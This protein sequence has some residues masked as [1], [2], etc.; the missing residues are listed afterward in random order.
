LS[1]FFHGLWERHQRGYLFVCVLLFELSMVLFSRF[2]WIAVILVFATLLVGLEFL[3]R[4]LQFLVKNN[5]SH[6][7]AKPRREIPR[8]YAVVAG[9]IILLLVESQFARSWLIL[10]L[11]GALMAAAAIAVHRRYEER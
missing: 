4:Q 11:V 8:A 2:G 10:T 3:Y 1:D 7:W 9:G 5:K 6:W